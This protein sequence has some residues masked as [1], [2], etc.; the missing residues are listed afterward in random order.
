M[1][2]REEAAKAAWI[3][4]DQLEE[5]LHDQQEEEKMKKEAE[6]RERTEEQSVTPVH[7]R[8][9]SPS[10]GSTITMPPTLP[11]VPMKDPMDP[12]A[13]QSEIDKDHEV[14]QSAR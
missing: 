2:D 12:T 4:R 5:A 7:S 11:V 9:S 14:A 1:E 8:P 3:K 10:G 13:L 6:E